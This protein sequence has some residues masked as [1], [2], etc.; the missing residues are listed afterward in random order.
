[1]NSLIEKFKEKIVEIFT[2]LL[3]LILVALFL[4][5]YNLIPAETLK[6]VDPF[7]WF[8]VIFGLF[9]VLIILVAIIL[10]QRPKFTFIQELGIW[11]EKKTGN[12]FCSKCKADGKIS[13]LY[14]MEDR[15]HCYSCRQQ[16]AKPGF[17]HLT[18]KKIIHKGL[19]S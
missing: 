13:P 1:M 11:K 5:G 19:E 3:F 14:E 8:K 16:Y 2:T 10:K 17:Q 15:Y 9:F 4:L 6:K 7:L 12:H 18:A